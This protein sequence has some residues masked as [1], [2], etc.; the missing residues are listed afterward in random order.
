MDDFSVYDSTFYN[1]L[2]NLELVLKKCEESHLVL[3]WEKCHFMG[4]E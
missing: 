3:N 1:C 2:A 4:N